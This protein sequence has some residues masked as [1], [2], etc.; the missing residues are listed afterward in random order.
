MNMIPRKSVMIRLPITAISSLWLCFAGLP[1]LA[2]PSGPAHDHLSPALLFSMSVLFTVSFSLLIGMAVYYGVR[3]L[4]LLKN[5]RHNAEQGLRV[6]RVASVCALVSTLSIGILSWFSYTQY[7]RV[8]YSAPEVPIGPAVSVEHDATLHSHQSQHGGMVQ[9]VGENHIEAFL[10]KGGRIQFYV[11]GRDEAEQQSIAVPEL[12]AEVQAQGDTE[13]VPVMLQA[14]PQPGEAVGTAS[15]FSGQ[16]SA[17]WDG[18]PLNMMLTVP[19]S[20]KLYRVRFDL[21]A[22]T[23]SAMP[24]ALGSEAERSLF[25]TPKGLYSTADI[26]ANGSLLPSEKYRGF[27]S[28][29]NM[30]PQLGDR[31]CPITDTLANPKLIWIVGGRKYSF[32]CPPCLEEF[33]ARAKEKPK[34]ILPPEEYVKR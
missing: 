5:R 7:L 2:H 4:M 10:A 9:S 6:N 19:L 31:I 21:A 32:C 13:F 33:V 14:L 29:H 11:L 24:A 22:H 3:Y 28:V 1:A 8:F 23:D 25:L 27:R 12:Q 15:H 17:Q 18:R 16:V 26:R 30:H 34:T 20:G